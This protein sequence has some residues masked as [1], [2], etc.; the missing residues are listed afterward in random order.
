MCPPVPNSAH[1]GFAVSLYRPVYELPW[2]SRST[3]PNILA[4]AF[5]LFGSTLGLYLAKV[6][7]VSP[8][9]E[10]SP[11]SD[12][13]GRIPIRRQSLWD[14]IHRHALTEPDHQDI[15]LVIRV[16]PMEKSPT[17]AEFGN[18]KAWFYLRTKMG[19]RLIEEV[20]AYTAVSHPLARDVVR[21]IEPCIHT[22]GPGG[23]QGL[24]GKSSTVIFALTLQLPGCKPP[25]CHMALLQGR[26]VNPYLEDT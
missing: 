21:F 11:S 20:V 17:P 12:G 25:Y 13:A 2:S 3:R 4:H 23:D 18:G 24:I 19:M 7:S 26:I 22:D 8:P 10:C 16:C 14:R 5:A 6:L 15:G 9:H 1:T